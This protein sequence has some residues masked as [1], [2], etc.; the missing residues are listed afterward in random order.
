MDTEGS[1]DVP[2]ILQEGL[3]LTSLWGESL[4][5]ILEFFCMGDWFTSYLLIIGLCLYLII[6]N[7]LIVIISFN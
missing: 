4:G 1:A 5:N 3:L 7:F 2:P 6:K